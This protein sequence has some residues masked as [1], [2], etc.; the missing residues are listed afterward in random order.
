MSGRVKKATQARVSAEIERG[1]LT[2]QQLAD[3]L[4]ISLDH[5]YLATSGM[6][7]DGLLIVTDRIQVYDA[8]ARKRNLVFL[9][10]KPGRDPELKWRRAAPGTGAP[11]QAPTVR[12]GSGQI[13]GHVYYRQLSNWR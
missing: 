1:P 9:F 2:A 10:G 5:I 13:A 7:R 6:R 8:H 12:A 11:R 4:H 3:R